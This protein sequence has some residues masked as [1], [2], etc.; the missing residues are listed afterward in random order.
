MTFYGL[1][2]Y[3]GFQ[4]HLSI[5]FQEMELAQASSS[6]YHMTKNLKMT[7]DQAPFVEECHEFQLKALEMVSKWT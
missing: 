7:P 2:P 1:L 3:Q 6:S 4:P 5:F